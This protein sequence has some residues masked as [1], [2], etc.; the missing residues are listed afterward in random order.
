MS[1]NTQPPAT[2]DAVIQF[3]GATGAIWSNLTTPVPR[4]LITIESDTG[5]LKRGD[6]VTLYTSLP[7]FFDLRT[8]ENPPNSNTPPAQSADLAVGATIFGLGA[9]GNLVRFTPA[10]V[11]TLMGL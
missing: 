5:I 4:G 2:I 10:Q 7:V 8:L 11:R 9:S 6:G 1:G 3:S